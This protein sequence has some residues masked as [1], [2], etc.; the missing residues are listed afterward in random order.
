MKGLSMEDLFRYEEGSLD[1]AETER[2]EAAIDADPDLRAQLAAIR[3][4]GLAL[5]L[6]STAA[7]NPVHR[8]DAEELFGRLGQLRH[9]SE[10]WTFV[11]D[12][13]AALAGLTSESDSVSGR[14]RRVSEQ[15]GGP[16]V[17]T[18]FRATVSRNGADYVLVSPEW[19]A[20]YSLHTLM[21]VDFKPTVRTSTESVAS[22]PRNVVGRQP[23]PSKVSDDLVLSADTTPREH[24]VASRLSCDWGILY[25]D[26]N[27]LRLSVEASLLGGWDLDAVVVEATFSIAGGESVVRRQAVELAQP[28]MKGRRFGEVT[29]AVPD[30]VAETQVTLRMRS[31]E[32]TDLH[33]VS[34]ETRDEYLARFPAAPLVASPA[35]DGFRFRPRW[36]LQHQSLSN[37]AAAWGLQVRRSK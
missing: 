21:L 3:R 32:A 2:V 1:D 7:E 31:L 10:W 24:P 23:K 17:E 30:R 19:P 16:R 13:P 15:A 26:P 12:S 8:R 5:E 4:Q 29:L 34:R 27:E 37:P 22:L 20:G 9:E 33:L 14:I 36:T 18:A 25:F 6:G 35:G 28:G 11:A